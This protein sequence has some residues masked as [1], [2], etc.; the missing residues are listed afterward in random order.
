MKTDIKDFPR[1][2]NE[3]DLLYLIWKALLGMQGGSSDGGS[4]GGSFEQLQAD[5]EQSDSTAADYIKN[6]PSFLEPLVVAGTIDGSG[7]FTPGEGAATWEETQGQMF[8]GGLV[9]LLQTDDGE[10]VAVFLAAMANAG[11]IGAP[12]D[13]GFVFWDKPG[14][15]PSD[16]T[17]PLQ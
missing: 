15:E 8:N 4:E 12:T 7:Y 1:G 5:W 9:Y 16:D 13:E 10:P 2:L 6:K 14:D 11:T 17:G 3:K